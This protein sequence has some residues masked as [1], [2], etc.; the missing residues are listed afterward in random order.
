MSAS[1]SETEEKGTTHVLVEEEEMIRK[2]WLR[3]AKA[4]GL[5][6][7]TYHSSEAFLDDLRSG[8]FRG[9][10]RFYLDQDMHGVRGV[11]VKLAREL[12]CRWPEAFISLVTAY[13]KLLFRR[14]L[15]QGV[16]TEVYGKFPS[17]FDNPPYTE[18]E[19]RYEREV[20][21]P[22]L[23]EAEAIQ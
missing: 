4:K 21:M 3:I 6:L 22:L 16:V 9:D 15:A 13:P 19:E 7:M 1:Q 11:G 23:V 18:F 8:V 17:P 20:W 10:D 2:E 12:R 14:E 5:P